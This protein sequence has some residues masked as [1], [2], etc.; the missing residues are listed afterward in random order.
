MQG[1]GET[2]QQLSGFPSPIGKELGGSGFEGQ[3]G[4]HSVMRKTCSW[5]YTVYT[6]RGVHVCKHGRVAKCAPLAV[7]FANSV[8]ERDQAGAQGANTCLF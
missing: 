7:V 2:W 3:S 6:G 4:L 1:C 5:G 8:C